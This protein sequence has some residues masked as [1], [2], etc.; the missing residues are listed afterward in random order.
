LPPSA[1]AAFASLLRRRL[2]RR[3]P[4]PAM[5]RARAAAVSPGRAVSFDAEPSPAA[6]SI[7]ARPIGPEGDLGRRFRGPAVDHPRGPGPR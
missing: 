6:A 5:R 3:M 1:A 2:R 4:S 7:A